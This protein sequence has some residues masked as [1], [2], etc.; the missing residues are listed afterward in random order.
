[1]G[2]V[3]DTEPGQI[4]TCQPGSLKQRT[5]A[6]RFEVED[7]RLPN[8]QIYADSGITGGDHREW[9]FVL[10]DQPYDLA[11]PAPEDVESCDFGDLRPVAAFSAF[12]CDLYAAASEWKGSR[13]LYLLMRPAGEDAEKC[14]TGPGYG[15]R[16][17]VYVKAWG[18]VYGEWP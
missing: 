10:A 2:G 12:N 13:S 7:G 14:G 8:V 15:Y 18:S 17:S 9:R 16:C 4:W 11:Q 6:V 5:Y 1:M 3:P